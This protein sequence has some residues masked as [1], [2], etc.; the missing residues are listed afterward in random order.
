MLACPNISSYFT[1]FPALQPLCQH[2]LYIEWLHGMLPCFISCGGPLASPGPADHC[3]LSL[4]LIL[5][6]SLLLQCSSTCKRTSTPLGN[7]THITILWLSISTHT[8]TYTR[9]PALQCSEH[10]LFIEWGSHRN[11]V[12][13]SMPEIR[14]IT[15][16]P[17]LWKKSVLLCHCF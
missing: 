3:F 2:L 4:S 8:H 11:R 10:P 7:I 15:F 13:A 1:R 16:P 12:E 14:S 17:Q 6:M 5:D 9:T